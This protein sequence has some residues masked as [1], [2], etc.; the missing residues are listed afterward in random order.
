M[1]SAVQ[2]H[3]QCG[4]LHKQSEWLIA[5][6]VE[7]CMLTRHLKISEIP[8]LSLTFSPGAQEAMEE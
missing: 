5:S 3:Q 6:H 8:S 7:R 4:V 1:T 2:H